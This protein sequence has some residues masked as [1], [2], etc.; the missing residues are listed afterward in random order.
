MKANPWRLGESCLLAVAV[1]LPSQPLKAQRL[2]DLTRRPDA[3]I[4][5]PF[6]SIAGV[7]GLP[8]SIAVVTDHIERLLFLVD[9][10]DGSLT[11][12]GRQGEGPAEYRFPSVPLAGPSNTT[13]V[14]DASLQRALVV[15]PTGAIVS[16]VRLP[17]AGLPSGTLARGSDQSGR[18]YFEGNSFD[19]ERETFLD[20]VEVLR[21]NPRDNRLDTVSRVWSGG[22][23]IVNWPTGKASLARSITPY[24]A[25]DAWAVYPD[26]A[27][28]I[29]RHQPFRVDIVN[30]AGTVRRGTPLTYKPRPVT[31]ADRTMYRK[32]MSLVRSS[33][34]LKG[35]GSGGPQSSGI[36]VSDE[37]FPRLMPPFVAASIAMSPDG[38]LWIGRSH[39]ASDT[40]RYY[41]I[42][43]TRG[44]VVAT[45]KVGRDSKVVGFGLGT[46]YVARTDPA[47]D[48]VYLER[49][50]R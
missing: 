40:A 14:V 23:V 13:Y 5:E 42:L 4:H 39:S 26:G 37:E 35:G 31:A 49:Y 10:A 47:D 45:A 36:K 27:I 7:R 6:T 50:V 21:W 34:V 11:P 16:T 2:I 8:G 43:D 48:L 46:V 17:R 19:P 41:D 18:L 20:S 9:F 33:A 15:S 38:Q 24:P 1:L 30:T 22:R 3:V 28:A 25:L 29:V 32:R 44:G 12:I